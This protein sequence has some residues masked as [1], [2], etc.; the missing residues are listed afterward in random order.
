MRSPALTDAD[1]RLD[2]A[3]RETFPAS[4]P[5]IL[6]RV[7]GKENWDVANDLRRL[8]VAHLNRLAAETLALYVATKGCRW[9]ISGPRRHDHQRLLDE[10]ATRLLASLDGLTERVRKLGAGTIS[11]IWDVETHASRRCPPMCSAPEMLGWL[12]GETRSLATLMHDCRRLAETAGDIATS[13]LLEPWIED[14][15]GRC[16]LLQDAINHAN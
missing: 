7:A 10:L 16:L 5:V 1:D 14:A 9:H 15:E 4:D 8:E 6:D 11:S 2:E 3:L 12:L 13:G